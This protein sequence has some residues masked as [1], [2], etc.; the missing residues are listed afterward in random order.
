FDPVRAKNA[1]A[2]GPVLL[3]PLGLLNTKQGESTRACT[4]FEESV[5]LFKQ[6][7]N[8]RGLAAALTQWAGTLFISQA[9]PLLFDPLLQEGVSLQREVGDQEG[10]AGA[11]ALPRWGVRPP[12]GMAALPPPLAARGG[13]Y[14][15]GRSIMG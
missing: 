9:E 6:V 3:F 2:R 7:G 8:K 1:Q 5:T 15:R 10:M 12:R 13:H 4:L 11:S 14:R